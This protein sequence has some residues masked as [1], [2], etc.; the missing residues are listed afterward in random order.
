M[1][2]GEKTEK[3][4][5][6]RRQKARQDGQ[7]ARS[8]DLPA[9]LALAALMAV[10]ALSPLE[11][12]LGWRRLFAGL[13]RGAAAG[14][15]SALAAAQRTNALVVWW[16][17]PA[18]A[19][20]WVA[21][22]AASVAQG[23][24]IVSPKPFQPDLQRLNPVRNI[25][26][27]FSAA[28]LSR[29]L[30]SLVPAGAILYVAYDTGRAAWPQ[31]ATAAQGAP[32]ALLVQQLRWMLAIA[33]KSSLILLVWGG[34]DYAMQRRT[35]T[36]GLRMSKDEVKHE[37]R[38]LEGSP[39]IKGRQRRLRRTLYRRVMLRDVPQAT[40]V[41]VNP[42][43]YAIALRYDPETMAAPVVLAKGREHLARQIKEIAR[44]HGI[45]A[46]EN[47]PLAHA[48]YRAVE[49]GHAI[50]PSLY[51]AVAEIL[52]FIFATQAQLRR[53]AQPA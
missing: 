2:D 11:W 32:A 30:K 7:I 12:A 13:L 46:V 5:G 4:T 41:V 40:V 24:W 42:T 6:H 20:A 21:A 50:P 48:L 10:L 39:E 18:M 17:G 52:A 43:E 36:Q 23:G 9:A 35:F 25:Q 8:M 44:W 29:L 3:P 49:V 53:A 38:D 45:P 1:A 37:T 34:F 47:P 19:A 27:L 14:R 51:A 26:A 28:S 33:W 22:V 15:W 16:S 31:L